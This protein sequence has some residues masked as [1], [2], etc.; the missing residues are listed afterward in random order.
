MTAPHDW[1]IE[2]RLEYATRTLEP[3]DEQRF[4]AH[5]ASCEE[6]QVEIA[7]IESDLRWL[8]AA[9]TPVE[10]RPRFTA[11]ATE[12]VL[13]RRPRRGLPRWLAPAVLA[14]SVLLVV[15]GWL[16]TRTKVGRLEQELASQRAAIAALMDTLSISRGAGRVLQASVDVNG[17]RGGLLI[18]ADE[19]THRWNV[20]VHGLP[21]A[22][23][24]YRY[25]FWFICDDGMVRGNEVQASTSKPTM[26]TTGMP[27]PQS[28]PA[29]KG[30]ELTEEPMAEDQGPPRGKS[31]AQLML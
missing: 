8:P 17:T 2:N 24:G 12:R 7:R 18:F 19:T 6:C 10:P 26:F 15:G 28:C 21:P 16:A 5:L 31:L 3:E 25:Q 4:E 23:A 13:G 22:P 30:A 9:L 29:V 27:Q 14:A 20:V 1:F 11:R